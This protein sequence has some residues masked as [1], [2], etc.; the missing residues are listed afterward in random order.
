MCLHMRENERDSGGVRRLNG[1][2]VFAGF[3][4]KTPSASYTHTHTHK[5]ARKDAHSHKH[6]HTKTKKSKEFSSAP[7]FSAAATAG[8]FCRPEANFRTGENSPH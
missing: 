5:H 6:T 3:L 1:P 4:P 7:Q 8:H 2:I